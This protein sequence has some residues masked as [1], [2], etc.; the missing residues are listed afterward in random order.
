MSVLFG[1]TPNA[2]SGFSP[3]MLSHGWEP[4]TPSQ[5]LY[6]A[7][8]E[9][10]LGNMSLD[11]WEA[12]NYERVQ[13]LRDKAYA[14]YHKTSERRKELLDKTSHIRDFKVGQWVWYRTLCGGQQNVCESLLP[15]EKK[16][17][18]SIPEQTL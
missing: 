14:N 15:P 13:E 12:E 18:S 4:N 11:N 1:L 2:A 9:N 5:L 3:F 17:R 10:H 8:V 7:W 16:G 6:Y